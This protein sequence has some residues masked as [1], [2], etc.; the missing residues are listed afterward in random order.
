MF[1]E[2]VARGSLVSV[3]LS[4]EFFPI[5]ALKLNTQNRVP[6]RH[7]IRLGKSPFTQTSFAI[8]NAYYISFFLKIKTIM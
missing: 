2:E 4:I 8:K 6:N 3:I 7:Y 5:F 1:G